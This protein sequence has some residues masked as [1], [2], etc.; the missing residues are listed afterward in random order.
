MQ[1]SDPFISFLMEAPEDQDDSHAL[2]FVLAGTAGAGK[3]SLLFS[4]IHGRFIEGFHTTVGPAVSDWTGTV[5]D[6]QYEVKVW[7]TAGQE[8]YRALTPVYFREASAGIIV[9]DATEPDAS[10]SLRQWVDLF[11][12]SALDSAPVMIAANKIDLVDD[13]E[14]VVVFGQELRR[15]L[16]VEFSMVSAKNGNGVAEMF[17]GL[18]GRV[19]V[20]PSE[21]HTIRLDR[22]AR[23]TGCAC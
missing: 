1:I 22:P 12:G 9:F 18:L 19:V 23:E 10:E 2:K 17:E 6:R 20:R 5:N 13:V 11:R 8:R 7:D 3:T 16:G 14:R 21:T 15:E 4:L